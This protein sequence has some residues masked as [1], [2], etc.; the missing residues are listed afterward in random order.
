VTARRN[1]K[2]A[3]FGLR[4]QKPLLEFSNHPED[5]ITIP[6]QLHPFRKPARQDEQFH[7]SK[8]NEVTFFHVQPDYREM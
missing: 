7:Q 5:F 1:V 6:G 8:S 2:L 4:I 3:A